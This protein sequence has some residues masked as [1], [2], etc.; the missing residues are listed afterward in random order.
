MPRSS[1]PKHAPPPSAAAAPWFRLKRMFGLGD[2]TAAQ[3]AWGAGQGG[4]RLPQVSDYALEHVIARNDRTT[5]YQ[6][7]E[8]ASGRMTALKTVRIGSGGGTDRGLWRERFLREA[9]AAARLRHDCIVHT[10]A[11]GV[12]GEGDATTGWLAMEWVHGT[13]MSRYASAARLLPEGMVVAIAQRVALGLDFAHRAGIVHRDI[14]P[15]NV[16]FDPT[17]GTVKVTD[18]GSARVADTAATRSGLIMGTPAYM[19]PEQLSGVDATPQCDL[20]ALGVTLFELLVGHRPFEADSMGDLLARIAHQDAPRLRSLRPELPVLLD[21]IVARLLAKAPGLRQDS[22]RQ[23]ALELRLARA[24][25]APASL[26][27][28]AA[29]WPDTCPGSDSRDSLTASS[30]IQGTIAN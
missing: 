6:A 5:I 16:L 24:Q 27:S 3:A 17:T 30:S 21:E 23:V 22:A 18:F 14:K 29:E 1:L 15:S 19:A 2:R 11:G 13:D 9:A 26:G 12:T 10:Y 28:L 8:R 25:C 20:Y 7:T 4:E